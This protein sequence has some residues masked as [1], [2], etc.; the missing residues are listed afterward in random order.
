MNLIDRI[1]GRAS[2][3][4]T[5]R[6]EADLERTKAA[7]RIAVAVERRAFAAA[8]LDRL[9]DS[10]RTTRQEINDELRSDL[11]ALRNRARNLEHDNDYAKRF[12]GMCETH[13]IGDEP[14]RLVSTVENSPG[15]A[16]ELA[17]KVIETGW[18]DW[19]KRGICEVSGAYSLRTLC[20]NI[21]R[22]TARDG[23]YILRHLRNA[24]AG[25]KYGYALQVID[26]DRLATRLYRERSDGQNAI[27][28]GIERDAYG[29][30]IAAHFYINN[31]GG[32]TE[33]ILAGEL[34]HKFIVTRAGQA[35]GIPWMHAAML[36]MHYAGEFSISALVAAKH[37]ADHLG[38]FVSPDGEAP[39]LGDPDDATGTQIMTSAP[40]TYDTIAAGYDFKQVDSKYPYVVFA[41]F[42]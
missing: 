1:T 35:R 9:T 37:G 7:A 14:P 26:V 40:G 34:L 27:H 25:N 15:V 4:E 38:F 8:R 13:I 12:L 6:L 39:L 20:W 41:P 42:I 11:D 28:T 23:E 2:R 10:W 30:F 19:G 31:I 5:L 33:R 17:I 32:P 3:N 24:N 21:V 16:D 22:G 36:S 18:E 29:R